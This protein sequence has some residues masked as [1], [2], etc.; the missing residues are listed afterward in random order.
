M[1]ALEFAIIGF[2]I[3]NALTYLS[4]L[5]WYRK[6]LSGLSDVEFD[7]YVVKQGRSSFRGKWIG[8]LVRCHA[9]TGFWVG[10]FLS[11]LTGADIFDY[12]HRIVGCMAGGFFL[13]CTSFFM[14]LVARKL[15]AEEL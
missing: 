14:W 7:F 12:G 2:G 6:I 1:S 10:V 13:S 9:C 5:E 11:Y 8:K 15:G 3:T 4:V